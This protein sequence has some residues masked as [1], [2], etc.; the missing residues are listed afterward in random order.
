MNDPLTP[1]DVTLF[2]IWNNHLGKIVE[3]GKDMVIFLLVHYFECFVMCK[4]DGKGVL[5]EK[6][7]LRSE[8]VAH[9]WNG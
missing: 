8:F 7:N 2:T 6:E 5:S 9:P 4:Y 3:F 1:A